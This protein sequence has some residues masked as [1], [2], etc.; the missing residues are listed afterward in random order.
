[1]ERRVAGRGDF[2]GTSQ[3]DHAGK[4]IEF[5][6]IGAF[7]IRR[8]LRFAPSWD[9]TYC[10]SGAP[11][12]I[13]IDCDKEAAGLALAYFTNPTTARVVGLTVEESLHGLGF[14]TK[15]Q[16]LLEAELVARGA[17]LADMLASAQNPFLERAGW[18]LGAL[19]ATVYI[20]S[21]KIGRAPWLQTPITSSDYELFSWLSC[22]TEDCTMALQLIDGDPV[23]RRLDPFAHSTQVFGPCSKGIRHRGELVGWCVTH[24]LTPRILQYSSIFVVAKHRGTLAPLMLVCESIREHLRRSK[25]LPNG[26]VAVL[27]ELPEMGRFAAKRLEP[28]ADS[29]ERVHVWWKMLKRAES[30]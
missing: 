6:A 1:V 5:R 15:L 30:P 22:G 12:A 8:Y 23:A 16:S 26:M 27:P 7:D 2:P 10:A 3:I 17:I 29:V 20:F 19:V 14:G 24:K 18:Q 21:E 11:I 13:G 9:V 28:W 4:I 25:D